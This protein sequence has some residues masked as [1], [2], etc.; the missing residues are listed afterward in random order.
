MLFTKQPIGTKHYSE[1][2]NKEIRDELSKMIKELRSNAMQKDSYYP[3][4]YLRETKQEKV[5]SGCAYPDAVGVTYN[6]DEDQ[7][8]TIGLIK[9]LQAIFDLKDSDSLVYEYNEDYDGFGTVTLGFSREVKE[10]DLEYYNK[11]KDIYLSEQKQDKVHK[12][13]YDLKKRTGTDIPYYQAKAA[14]EILESYKQS[15]ENS[16]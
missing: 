7:R 13:I 8:I 6:A 2:T 16:K 5:S 15:K 12:F 10:T 1:M 4:D 14:M 3:S 9:E 11:I